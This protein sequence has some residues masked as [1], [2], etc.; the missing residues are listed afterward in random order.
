MEHW[1]KLYTLAELQQNGHVIETSISPSQMSWG[2]TFYSK[3]I[4]Y[5]VIDLGIFMISPM[6]VDIFRFFYNGLDSWHLVDTQCVWAEAVDAGFLNELCCIAPIRQI[7][8]SAV[9]VSIYIFIEI[10]FIDF[11]WCT[12]LMNFGGFDYIYTNLGIIYTLWEDLNFCHIVRIFQL[13]GV[14]EY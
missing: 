3:C 1:T 13:S 11:L 12:Y 9:N 8:R 4:N 14:A 2:S 10:N 6:L 5:H 7:I